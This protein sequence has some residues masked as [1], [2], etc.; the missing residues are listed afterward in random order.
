MINHNV[1]ELKQKMQEFR[2]VT[3]ELIEAVNNDRD[4][5]LDNLFVKRQ[6]IINSVEKLDYNKRDFNAVCEELNVV[7]LSQSLEET[8]VK[9]RV[10][11]RDKMNDL[12]EKKT[13]NRSYIQNSNMIRSVLNTKI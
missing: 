2:A 1:E 9:K 7:K 6:E 8:I 10:E 4:E 12:K 3:E 11:T 13:A 5:E